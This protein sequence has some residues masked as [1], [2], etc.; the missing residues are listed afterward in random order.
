MSKLLSVAAFVIVFEAIVFAQGTYTVKDEDFGCTDRDKFERLV[1]YITDRDK[2]AF[3]KTLDA[4]LLRGDCIIF[5]VGDE[6]YLEDSGGIFS[7]VVKLRPKGS[8]QE[9]WTFRET[10]H[11][12]R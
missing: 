10:I 12:R 8:T 6:V 4:G 9:F 7:G 3:Q 1:R 11:G 5:K 2:E